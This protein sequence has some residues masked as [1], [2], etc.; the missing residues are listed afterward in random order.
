M[1]ILSSGYYVS[2]AKLYED[3][4][5]GIHMKGKVFDAL[6]FQ[7]D[8][9]VL[10]ASKKTNVEVEKYSFNIG[11]FE[12]FNDHSY[13]NIENSDLFIYKGDGSLYQVFSIVDSYSIIDEF[14][15]TYEYRAFQSEE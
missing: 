8:G 9:R 6:L 2:P 14:G 13:F 3:W 1:I 10:I 5:A 11:E 15:K 4:H 7:E 12:R